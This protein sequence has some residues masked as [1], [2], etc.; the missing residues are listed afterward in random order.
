MTK[1]L[2]ALVAGLMLALAISPV[3]AEPNENARK[4]PQT[5]NC[6]SNNPNGGGCPR[7][8]EAPQPTNP[9]CLYGNHTGNPHCAVAVQSSPT[10]VRT[11]TPVV[12]T[13]VTVNDPEPSATPTPTAPVV[14]VPPVVTPTVQPTPPVFVP[15]TL[16]PPVVT[17]TLIPPAI[18]PV[19]K[20]PPG[21]IPQPPATG[22][23]GLR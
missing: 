17:E 4:N 3:G 9:V 12:T 10:P 20:A 23:A 5:T 7:G 22:N 15:T 1:V 6:N 2:A 8:I 18:P 14:T 21:L 11:A 13:V 19:T 16:A